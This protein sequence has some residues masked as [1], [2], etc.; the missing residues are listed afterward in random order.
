MYPCPKCSGVGH[1]VKKDSG[2]HVG[3]SGTVGQ[4]RST[5]E[6]VTDRTCFEWWEHEPA[7]GSLHT[8]NEYMLDTTGIGSGSI[9]REHNLFATREEAQAEADRRNDYVR[10]VR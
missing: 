6:T 4:I 2:F 8:V 10:G 9:R 5:H 7:E 3:G 1:I